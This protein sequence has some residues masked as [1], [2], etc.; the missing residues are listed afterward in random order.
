MAEAAQQEQAGKKL[1]RSRVGMVLSVSGEKTI[2]VGIDN[3][4]RHAKYGKYIRRRTK[5]LVHDPAGEARVGD[6]VEIVPC[7]RLSRR[8]AWR[9]VGVLRRSDLPMGPGGQK[10]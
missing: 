10:G 2:N 1:A 4:V 9:L 5:L 6:R 3:L 8:K 7:R